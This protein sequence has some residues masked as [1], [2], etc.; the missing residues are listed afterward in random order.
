M[1]TRSKDR[2]KAMIVK[3]MLDIYNRF[4]EVK[5]SIDENLD[6]TI[7]YFHALLA[8]IPQSASGPLITKTPKVVRKK[9]MQRIETIPEDDVI[10]IDTS[11][12]ETVTFNDKVENM[13]STAQN[14]S[15]TTSGRSRREA[16][17]RAADNIRIQQSISILTKQR[18]PA[19]YDENNTTKKKRESRAK[20]KKSARSSSDDE[21]TQGPRKHTKTEASILKENIVKDSVDINM[22]NDETIKDEVIQEKKS[23]TL[24]SS[25]LTWDASR[26]R[27]FSSDNKKS[28]IVN[29]TVIAPK[30]DG[31][32]EASMYEDAIE[33]STP[34]MN[35]TMNLN[36]TH[37]VN[38][39]MN[40]T[41]VLEPLS[42]VK[43][44]ETRTITKNTRNSTEKDDQKKKSQSK[45][46]LKSPKSS[47]IQSPSSMALQDRMQQLKE[48]M[49]NKEFDELIT[50]DESSPDVKKHRPNIKKQES[51]KRFRRIV[52]SSSSSED[53]I[54]STP[55]KP[56]LKEMKSGVTRQEI[57]NT[58][59]SNALFSPYAKESVKKR[60]EA[61]EQAGMQSPKTVVDIDAPA[62]LTRTKTRAIAAAKAEV[63][64][65]VNTTEKTIAHKL[66][67][68]SV[69]KAKKISLAKH[70]KMTDEH[71]ENKAQSVQRIPRVLL[72]DK[73]N[74]QQKT[75]PLTKPKIQLPMSVSRI[76]QT[77][78]NN[79]IPN[80][81]ATSATRANIIT[82][83]ESFIQ[84]T[85]SVS[86]RNSP[87]KT[88]D[89]KRKLNDEDARKK[90]DEALRI[91]TEEKRRKRQEKEL[92]NKLAREAKEKLELEKRQ[93][94]EKEREERARLAQQ[95]QEKQR[96]ELEKKRLAQLQRAQEKDE[97]RRQEEQF[98]LQRLQEQEEAE[99]LLAEQRRREQEAD[100]RKEMEARAQQHATIEAMKMKNQMLQ[101]QAK[102]GNKN[103]GP[104][105]Y[106]LD[107]EP[108]EDESDD[109]NR[110]KHAIP[111]WAQP[112]V[113]KAQ[114][115]MQRYIPERAILK[116]F[117]SKKCTPD[118]TQ[119]FQG[120]D[121]SRLLRTSSAI[122]NTPPRYS[123]MET[124]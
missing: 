51:K 25:S 103:H 70:T 76:P 71:K 119:L 63:A 106:I 26:K 64:E 10:I 60:V 118:L 96:E 53:E 11:M 40:V 122:W 67:R 85:K 22:D 5:K 90:R 18:R 98:R 6:E 97:K 75:T 47:N 19:S 123:M 111:H 30:A 74:Q 44:N 14:T 101:A 77:P 21:P 43:M 57:K 108:D 9:G 20:R 82:S 2:I 61:F 15:E 37:V 110:P 93:K 105:N 59:K 1:G 41:V 102:H 87:D 39:M 100:K 16:S 35:S 83:M 8:Q 95:V 112:H 72:P 99:R 42:V 31:M 124:E 48:V 65:T 88:E 113:R 91:V 4:T 27:S 79:I 121:R 45:P 89:R 49:A 104:T 84:P 62:R 24:R 69:A 66:A 115:A 68:K 54:L 52:E 78:L 50:E 33:K 12:S 56:A 34:I 120:I 32:E 36:S 107:S 55:A 28:N 86:K 109:E 80:N 17:K 81:K 94:A 29:D 92:K 58:Y 117:D 73:G 116:F 7:D 46:E 38:K 23:E 114:L 3:D 13:D